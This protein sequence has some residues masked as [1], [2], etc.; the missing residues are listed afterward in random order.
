MFKPRGFLPKTSNRNKQSSI[1]DLYPELDSSDRQ[2]EAEF[3]LLRYLEIVR[4]IFERT[5]QD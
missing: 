2:Q 4:R 3:Y 5:R 1:A